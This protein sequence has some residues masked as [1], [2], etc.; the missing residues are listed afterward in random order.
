MAGPFRQT[1]GRIFR[2]AG[3]ILFL[4]IAAGFLCNHFRSNGLS[5]TGGTASGPVSPEGVG[6]IPLDAARQAFLSGRACFVD[7]RDPAAYRAG[8][9]RGARSLPWEGMDETLEK[10]MA[11]VPPDALII[12]Y[13]DGE[14][15]DLSARLAKEIYFRG[16]DR[17]R[18]LLNGWSRWKAAGLPWET[19]GGTGSGAGDEGG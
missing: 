17:V 7:A 1:G 12:T 10:A 6:M 14:T 8:H 3:L 15:C 18:I 19:G 2:Q 5:L 11:G 9:I 16:Y 13:C 4:G